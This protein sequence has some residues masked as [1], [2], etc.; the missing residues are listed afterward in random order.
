[1]GRRDVTD[2]RWIDEVAELIAAPAVA[3]CISLPRRADRWG[4]F[5]DGCPV[6]DSIRYF[7]AYDGKHLATPPGMKI[8][9]SAWGCMQSHLAIWRRAIC[10]GY[11]LHGG[12]VV[13]FEDD[14][15]FV[16]RFAER[17]LD[18]IAR[19]P[20]GWDMLYL[21]GQHTHGNERKPTLVAEGIHQAYSVNR[22]HGYIMR[23]KTI[24]TAYRELVDPTKALAAPTFHVDHRLET[25]HRSGEVA[26]YSPT[27]WL[28]GQGAGQSDIARH[29]RPDGERWWHPDGR[30]EHR[31]PVAR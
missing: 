20:A 15:V 9:A 1:V 3:W 25:L 5:V 13:V 14:A 8:P 21:G 2:R 17:S 19:A 11:H 29:A 31:R 12:A 24:S 22:T 18:L 6:A 16:E 28:V 4:K 27:Q 7:P 23:G 26:V 10:E 30:Y